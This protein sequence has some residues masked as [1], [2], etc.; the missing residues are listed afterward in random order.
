MSPTYTFWIR[1]YKDPPNFP[2]AYFQSHFVYK[3]TR[4]STTISQNH[5]IFIFLVCSPP[6]SQCT[7]VSFSKNKKT[8]CTLV[9]KYMSLFLHSNQLLVWLYELLDINLIIGDNLNLED[10]TQT[11]AL[12]LLLIWNN[13]LYLMISNPYITKIQIYL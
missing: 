12:S 11:K 6:Q 2:S 4:T 1:I 3:K 7:L 10:F 9:S 13:V 8:Q 5:Y